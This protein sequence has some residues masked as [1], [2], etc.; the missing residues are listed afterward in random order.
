MAAT[1]EAL[2]LRRYGETAAMA[3]TSYV[4]DSRLFLFD[5]LLRVVRVIVLLSIWRTILGGKGAVSGMTLGAVL[6]YTLIAEVFGEQL[7]CSTRLE[8]SL[9][10]GSI[11][12][13]LLQPM[14]LAA[15][16]LADACGRWAI[17]FVLFSAPL[18]ACAPLLGVD[19]RPVSALAGLLFVLSLVLGVAVGLALE[20]LFGGL[21][22]AL[23]QGVWLVDRLRV[24]VT[25]LL[26]GALL[27]LALLPW[28]LGNVFGWLPFAS[29]A[30][31]P[32]KIYT[33]TGDPL[34]LLLL[35]T[36]WAV[37]LWPL[38]QRLWNANREKLVGYGG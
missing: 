20:F 7:N 19:P 36:G 5:Y 30:S 35:Q 38:A 28:G 4:G 3:A 8:T 18:L 13:H 29:M 17:G 27:P 37:V 6:T 9:W 16:F 24:A 10:E 2:A 11:T 15:Q 34:P 12:M 21:V 22:V 33:G 23:Q 31:A 25:L 14:G 32:L 1:P 26:S